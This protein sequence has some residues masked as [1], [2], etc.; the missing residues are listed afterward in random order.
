MTLAGCVAA[1]NA[2][3]S[4]WTPTSV[5]P[6]RSLRCVHCAGPPGT[7]IAGTPDHDH[8][9]SVDLLTGALKG[10]DLCAPCGV[11]LM[12]ARSRLLAMEP[13][14]ASVTFPVEGMKCG[15]RGHR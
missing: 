14:A 3:A 4:A 8:H 1:P 2:A 9:A 15:K 12:A 13:T 7:A 5:W 11:N 6:W 10:V